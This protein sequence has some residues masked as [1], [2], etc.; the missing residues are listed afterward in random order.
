MEKFRQSHVLGVSYK[1]HSYKVTGDDEYRRVKLTCFEIV[2]KAISPGQSLPRPSM[3]IMYQSAH[4]QLVIHGADRLFSYKHPRTCD[5]VL[6]EIMIC[7]ENVKKVSLYV[8]FY[9][10]YV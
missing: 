6:G 7:N 10:I 5:L 3:E 9:Y 8:Q 2:M 4:R 1:Y